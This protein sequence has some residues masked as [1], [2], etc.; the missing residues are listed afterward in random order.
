VI[1]SRLDRPNSPDSL[2]STHDC[3]S[4]YQKIEKDSLIIGM[5]FTLSNHSLDLQCSVCN[6]STDNL[7]LT[8]YRQTHERC[9]FIF[10]YY[11][12]RT[13]RE[14]M[15]NLRIELMDDCTRLSQVYKI[16]SVLLV[17]EYNS[18]SLI[19]LD[20]SNNLMVYSHPPTPMHIPEGFRTA[21]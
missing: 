17:D 13:S 7:L 19:K 9:P 6:N 20:V 2:S 16:A 15:L 11:S 12:R 18:I 14:Q 5:P 10:M 4:I 21:A 8:P 1:P 3:V